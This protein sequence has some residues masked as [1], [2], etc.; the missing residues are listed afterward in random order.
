M[1]IEEQ[2]KIIRREGLIVDRF[3]REKVDGVVTGLFIE[4]QGNEW[5]I[6]MKNGVVL[7]CRNLDIKVQSVFSKVISK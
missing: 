4:W 1:N 3:D 2:A 5:F 6:R 7:S